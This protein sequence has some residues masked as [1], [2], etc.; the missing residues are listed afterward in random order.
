MELGVGARV[1][2]GLQGDQR[3]QHG[4]RGLRA[5]PHQRH[6]QHPRRV[7]VFALR[8]PVG[9]GALYV[10][11][12]HAAT[13][14]TAHATRVVVELPRRARTHEQRVHLGLP[15]LGDEVPG[16]H[17]AAPFTRRAQS[18]WRG[19][20]STAWAAVSPLALIVMPP[21]CCCSGV[22]TRSPALRSATTS[23]PGRPGTTPPSWNLGMSGTSKPLPPTPGTQ[24]G[25]SNDSEPTV[26][27]HMSAMALNARRNGATNA[28]LIALAKPDSR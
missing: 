10:L 22:R 2:R 14:H 6:R 21:V 27:F 11:V 15:V 8:C 3:G 17:Q 7:D 1:P 16:R 19:I 20:T 25:T 4:I 18:S 5:D 26:L 9:N 13:E 28:S 24:L 12:D 23:W